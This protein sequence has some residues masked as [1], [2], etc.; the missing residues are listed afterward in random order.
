MLDLC[1]VNACHHLKGRKRI[2]KKCILISIVSS[3]Y[4]QATSFGHPWGH[5][6]PIYLRP[7]FSHLCLSPLRPST[8]VSG[9]AGTQEEYY[10]LFLA[11]IVVPTRSSFAGRQREG[12]KDMALVPRTSKVVKASQSAL[13]REKE[14][15]A[16]TKAANGQYKVPGHGQDSPSLSFSL[17]LSPVLS[18]QQRGILSRR[19]VGSSGRR[20]ASI[21]YPA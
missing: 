16:R 14:G 10:W 3:P 8:A 7:P 15:R 19:N 2:M 21:C 4:S 6:R 1:L 17:S 11:S 13:R 12:K 20:E 5:Y 9:G 18:K